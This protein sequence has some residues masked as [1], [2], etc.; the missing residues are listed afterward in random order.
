[1]ADAV[2]ALLARLG[3]CEDRAEALLSLK[4][5]V[6]A[7]QP[8][9]L[10]GVSLEPLFEI[11][12][13]GDREHTELCCA[14]LERAL[15]PQQPQRLLAAH[16]HNLTRGLLHPHELVRLLS[17]T[18][19]ERIVGDTSCVGDI[20]SQ[21]ELL[22]HVIECIRDDTTSVATQA[23]RCLVRVA[24]A[25]EGL[26]ALFTGA[27]LAKLNGV[28]ATSDVVRYRVYELV[29]EI[30]GASSTS[31]RYC[32]EA[33]FISRLVAELVG[34]DVLIRATSAE[35][36]SGLVRTP[37]GRHHLLHAGIVDRIAGLL[38]DAHSDP[39]C[40]LYLPGLVKFFA[41]LAV[42]EGPEALCER[43]P[44][45]LAAVSSM[46]LGPEPGLNSVALDTIGL[47]ARSAEGKRVLGKEGMQF[48][49]LLK[50]MGNLMQNSPTEMRAR[51]LD[52]IA[53]VL[54]VPEGEGE[55]AV[56]VSE[57]WFWAL[58]PRPFDLLRGICTQ[59]FPELH[60]SALL[61]LTAIAGQPWAQRLMSDSPGFV[62]FLTDRSP[63]PGKEAR[64]ARHALVRALAE[65]AAAPGTLGGPAVLRLRAHAREGPHHVRAEARIVA[66]EG[67]E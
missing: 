41:R 11:L 15:H 33:G 26:Q 59:P 8:S 16:R 58:A 48:P 57:R 1:M 46:L 64:E 32:D 13:C 5:A 52:T 47:I 50:R 20:A 53:A 34:N 62:E 23:V 24:A 54:S 17:L 45:F 25:R 31:L 18:L 66:V 27:L 44:P 6:F 30:A 56:E 7:S 51:C 10:A 28:M 21:P 4:T 22:S 42:L 61:V 19:I 9:T 43:Y 67:A 63:G 55:E 37:H 36:V 39:F 49:Q 40:D 29:V 2:S 35:T 12:D 60:C 14:V 3:G 65:S 38:Q